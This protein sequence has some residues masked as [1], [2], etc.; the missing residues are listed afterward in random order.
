[1][2]ANP[3]QQY[4]EQSLSTLTPGELLVKL[5]DEII[6]QLRI[7]K[8]GIE[9]KDFGSVNNALDKTQ[10]ILGTLE[11][12]LNMDYEVSKNLREL[13]IF[14]AQQLMQANLKKDVGPIDDCLP[15][16]RDLRES[17]DQADKITRMEKRGTVRSKAV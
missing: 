10:T 16:V 9:K 5:Y 3:Y 17:F 12:S 2:Q 4:K 6:K 14:M 1:M 8:L 15:L 11:S 7:A 13:Y